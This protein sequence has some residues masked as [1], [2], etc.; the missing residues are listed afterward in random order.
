[1]AT[2]ADKPEL[3]QPQYVCFLSDECSYPSRDRTW[4]IIDCRIPCIRSWALRK[5]CGLGGGNVQQGSI[6]FDSTT[7]H[8]ATLHLTGKHWEG[9]FWSWLSHISV[10][11]VFWGLC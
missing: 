6:C 9:L 5:P 4:P 11:V 1:M 10:G 8:G 3:V 2:I 7:C